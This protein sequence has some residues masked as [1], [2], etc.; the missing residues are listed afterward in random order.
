MKLVLLPFLDPSPFA[1]L[2]SCHHC[3]LLLMAA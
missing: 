1:F 2:A 3:H